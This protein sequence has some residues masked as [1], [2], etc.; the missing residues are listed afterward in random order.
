[1]TRYRVTY[2]SGKV[3]VIFAMSDASA[4]RQAAL[5]AGDVQAV[6]RVG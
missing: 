2:A 6:L 4:H 1:V 5:Y 3:R